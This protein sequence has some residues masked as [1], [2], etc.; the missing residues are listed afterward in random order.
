MSLSQE[1]CEEMVVVLCSQL[2]A[3]PIQ[4]LGALQV[5]SDNGVIFAR[6]AGESARLDEL[7]RWRALHYAYNSPVPDGP[8]WYEIVFKAVLPVGDRWHGFS[9]FYTLSVERDEH[10]DLVM[11]QGRFLGHILGDECAK[12]GSVSANVEP[13]LQT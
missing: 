2:Q 9:V 5:L 3:I 13:V 1:E 12:P 8:D 7:P 6:F 4:N 11:Y 10:G